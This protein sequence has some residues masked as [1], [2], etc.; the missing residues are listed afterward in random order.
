MQDWNGSL[1]RKNTISMFTELLGIFEE[2]EDEYYK[3]I[4]GSW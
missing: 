1:K 2:K 4:I 3:I